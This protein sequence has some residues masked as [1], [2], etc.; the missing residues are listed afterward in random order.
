LRDAAVPRFASPASAGLL[1]FCDP[2]EIPPNS[3]A[4][5]HAKSAGIRRCGKLTRF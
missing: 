1:V 3:A 5:V 2:S 4:T